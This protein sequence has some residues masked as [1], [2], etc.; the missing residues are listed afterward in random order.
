M[1]AVTMG[2]EGTAFVELA[3]GR[4]KSLIPLAVMKGS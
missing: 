4:G 3:Q 2:D 1:D